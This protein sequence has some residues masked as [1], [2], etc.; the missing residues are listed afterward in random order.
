MDVVHGVGSTTLLTSILVS[1][2]VRQ[3]TAM[4]QLNLNSYTFQPSFVQKI[5][6][7]RQSVGHIP[8][9]FE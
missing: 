4:N 2:V 6:S 8:I 1:T 5:Q 9:A 7:T 3:C